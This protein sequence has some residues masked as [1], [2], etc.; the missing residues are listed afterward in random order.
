LPYFTQ[1]TKTKQIGEIWNR[2]NYQIVN[3]CRSI[4]KEH[5][6]ERQGKAIKQ[7][8][9]AV[10]ITQHKTQPVLKSG[11]KSPGNPG[12]AETTTTAHLQAEESQHRPASTSHASSLGVKTH[13]LTTQTV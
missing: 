3:L 5:C 2:S 13:L 10:A 7:P 4:K 1:W 6:C 9:L 12:V 11:Y 8:S